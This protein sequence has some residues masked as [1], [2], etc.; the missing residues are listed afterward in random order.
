MDKHN[1]SSNQ[2]DEHQNNI[3]GDNMGELY[4][5][6][7]QFTGTSGGTPHKLHIFVKQYLLYTYFG[8]K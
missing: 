2:D 8:N 7:G 5:H 4:I 1:S 6:I 3:P